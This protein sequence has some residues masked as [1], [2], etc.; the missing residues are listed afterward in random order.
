MAIYREKILSLNSLKIVSDVLFTLD[1]EFRKFPILTCA[2]VL[3][4]GK[5]IEFF[6][7]PSTIMTSNLYV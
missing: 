1:L 2:W 7:L 6:N 4:L 3:L 5:W